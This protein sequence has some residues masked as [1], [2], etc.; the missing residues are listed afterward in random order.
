ME[1]T[2]PAPATGV[3]ALPDD[4]E[5]VRLYLAERLGTYAIA[6]RLGVH[7]TTV[8]RRLGPALAARGLSP[9]PLARDDI[10]TSE[11]VR[12]Y[13]DEGYS[14]AEVSEATGVPVSTVRAR[15][16]TDAKITLRPVV[17]GRRLPREPADPPV[18]VVTTS[19]SAE[20]AARTVTG[21]EWE[22]AG[23]GRHVLTTVPGRRV[24][25]EAVSALR[26]AGHA[27][28][29]RPLLSLEAESL[30]ADLRTFGAAR[31]M[32]DQGERVRAL[33]TATTLRGGETD[34]MRCALGAGASFGAVAEAVGLSKQAVHQRLR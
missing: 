12:L 23:D 29:C 30:L 13:V 28:S 18:W 33:S 34:L 14:L 4:D 2:E 22:P 24:A 19:A 16:L 6:K 3:A 5:L 25:S 15:L 21:E 32:A 10:D 27:A 11:L 17:S 20:V 31:A 26:A 1:T 7:R 9:R 8:V